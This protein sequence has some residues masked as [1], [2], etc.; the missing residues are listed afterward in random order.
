MDATVLEIA[1]GWV[2]GNFEL[3]VFAYLVLVAVLVLG[4]MAGR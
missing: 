2:F 1:R 4:W 3:I